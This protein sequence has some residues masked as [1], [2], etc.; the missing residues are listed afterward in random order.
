MK[1]IVVTIVLVLLLLFNLFALAENVSAKVNEVIEEKEVTIVDSYTIQ[2][3]DSGESSYMTGVDGEGY[4]K[5]VGDGY[6]IGDVIMIYHN[7]NSVNAQVGDTAMGDPQWYSSLKMARQGEIFGIMLFSIFTIL[8]VIV[9]VVY[10]KKI[11]T[12]RK[13][14]TV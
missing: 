4:Y 3:G 8:N 11:S 14:V 5:I 13:R 10:F 9:L 12:E 2:T 1:K 6:E 7:A